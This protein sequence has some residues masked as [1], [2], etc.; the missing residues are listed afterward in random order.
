LKRTKITTR[1]FYLAPGI[2]P[3]WLNDGDSVEV[4]RAETIFGHPF[5]FKLT[6]DRRNNEVQVTL[7]EGMPGF[8]PSIRA[9]LGAPL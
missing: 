8:A 2:L 1:I 7:T 3:H 6:H 9:D 4:N 5:G